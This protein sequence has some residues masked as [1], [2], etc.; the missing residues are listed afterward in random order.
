MR[1]PL[2]MAPRA[3]DSTRNVATRVEALGMNRSILTALCIVVA[4]AS[5]TL[6]APPKSYRL[7]GTDLKQPII[8]GAVCE[9]PD[10]TGLAF[11]GEDQKADDGQAHTRIKTKDGWKPL[12][13]ELRK[14]N[15]WQAHHHRGAEL[16]RRQKDLAARARRIY[17]TGLPLKERA[18]QLGELQVDQKVLQAELLRLVGDLKPFEAKMNDNR[19]QP[20]R[21][22]AATAA[23]LFK[24]RGDDRDDTILPMR[25][26]QVALE[27]AAEVLDAEPPPRALSPIV[28][29]EK[30]RLYVLFG[31][32][33]CDYLT[34][35]TWVFDPAK[36]QWRLR[37]PK[38]APPPRANHT[39]KVTGDGKVVLTGGYTY[40]S[41]TD[42]MGGQY[43]DHG[44]GD[45]TYDIAANTWS[46][47]KGVD[48]DGRVYRS[49]LFL[50]EHYLQDPRPD[51]AA[52]G[53]W[54]RQIP[55]NTWM[56][57]KTPLRPPLNRDWG[58]AVLD[59]DRDLILRFSGG[60]CAHGGSD[61]L[62]YHLASNRWELPFPVEFPLGQLYTNTEYPNGFNFN[63]RPWVTGHT[64]QSYGYDTITKRML[65]TGHFDHCYVYDPN[66][67]DWTTR[68]LKPKGMTYGG[69]FYTL[70]LCTTPHGL[71]AWTQEGKVFHYDPASK[72][73][74]ELALT[75]E[76][77][78]GSVVDNSTVLYDSKR[79][80]LLFLVKGYGDKSR[81]DGRLYAMDWK[82]KAVKVL[83]PAGREPAAAVPF[84]RECRYDVANDLVLVGGTLPPDKDGLRRT[85]A[86]DCAAE[87]WI[88]LKLAGTDPSGKT[89]RNVSLGLMYDAKREL[90]WAVDTNSNVFVLRLDPKTADAR[91][92]E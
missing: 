18:K 92:L 4:G 22:A 81:Y 8:W 64:Y 28:Y 88:S 62:H 90:F 58:T 59:P 91:P 71:A 89:G 86:Y 84:L 52:F 2:A 12:V 53:D 66:V 76:K 40:T 70:T 7:P 69:C 85:P 51:A 72:E 23:A 29:D 49:P 63:R 11:G 17:F 43:R 41:T 15:P 37:Y 24:S 32:D 79:D 14:N 42:Y 44:D 46:G 78:R 13:E 67:A 50:P 26:V 19:L 55:A 34:N 48:P 80:R 73:W 74:K 39:L 20:L 87:R 45:W 75:G 30:T 60:H 56:P 31:G 36:P 16:A 77:L 35:D 68:F 47:G 83:E 38:S 61:V 82:T 65:F 3:R 27:K 10:G 33:H 6:A 21:D 54:L 1:I 9:L 5:S 25:Q 57:T